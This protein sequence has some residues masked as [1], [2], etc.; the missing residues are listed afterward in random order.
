MILTF[1][2]NVALTTPAKT[3][4]A[5]ALNPMARAIRELVVWCPTSTLD[6]TKTGFRL[7]DRGAGRLLIPDAGS[8]GQ[9]NFAG[10]DEFNWAPIP[11]TAKAINMDMQLIEGPPFLLT[12]QFYN[13]AAALITVLGWMVVSEPFAELP[14]SEEYSFLSKQ[15]PVEVVAKPTT[16]GLP[17]ER[18]AVKK[19]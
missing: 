1:R 11:T 15:G 8:W 2:T 10:P 12:M 17:F 14:A 6:P 18:P 13:T 7:L 3:P 19:D 4:V 16:Q 5:I 9:E